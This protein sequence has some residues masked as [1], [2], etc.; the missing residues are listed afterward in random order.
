M[1]KAC[2]FDLDGVIVDTAKYHFVAWKKLANA[3]GFDFDEAF[4]EKLKGVSRIESLNLILE[5]GGVQ[6][7]EAEKDLWAARKNEWYLEYI[8]RMTADE[9][10]PGV[11]SFL[12]YCRNTGLK[13]ALGSASK[14]APAILERVGLLEYFDVIIDGNKT[15]RSKPDPEVF[16]LG[17][18]ALDASPRECVVFEDADKGI[19]AALAG[20]F[21]AVGVGQAEQL[22]LAHVVISGFE[23]LD[24]T[25]LIQTIT[26]L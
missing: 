21:F 7:T 4:N 13:I 2:I 25:Q 1:I 14:N 9:I 8:D 10:L 6:L 23:N 15:S 26:H 17:A 20:G 5:K 11:L 22:P 3:L 16:L 18:A 24:F 19:E 12:N